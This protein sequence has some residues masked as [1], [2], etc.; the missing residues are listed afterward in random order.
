MTPVCG[1]GACSTTK[2]VAIRYWLGV[3]S[4]EHVLRAVAVG[5]VQASHGA[6]VALE[7]MGESDGVVYYSPKTNIDGDTLREFTAIG[8]IAPGIVHQGES[9]APSSYRPWRR[10]IDYETDVVAASIRPL[11]SVLE[12]TRSNPD[13]GYQLRRGLL[14][15]SRHDFEV[16][17]RQMRR[18]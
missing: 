15:I 14:E 4:R 12:F 5:L 13:W 6:R 1:A 11:L 3:A 16:I 8:R 7:Q 2:R 10:H 9:A 18:E 17:R